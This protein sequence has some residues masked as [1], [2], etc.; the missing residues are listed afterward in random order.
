[1]SGN[2]GWWARE[3]LSFQRMERIAD[4]LKE[5]LMTGRVIPFVGAGVSIAV[6]DGTGANP[7]FPS[8]KQLLHCAADCLDRQAKPK[9][10]NVVRALLDVDEPDYLSGPTACR[11]SHVARCSSADQSSLD[12]RRQ[13]ARSR[14]SPMLRKRYP[15]LN[16]RC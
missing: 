13:L 14:P 7:L 1:M 2:Y 3:G 12:I 10:A 4:D 8:W 6:T 11:P 5:G 16:R 15:G 9:D